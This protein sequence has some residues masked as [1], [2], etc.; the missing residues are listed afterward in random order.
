MC[1][2]TRIWQQ[3]PNKYRKLKN[4]PTITLFTVRAGK[5]SD[6]NRKLLAESKEGPRRQKMKRVRIVRQIQLI[7]HF[8]NRNKTVSKL[9]KISRNEFDASICS[10]QSK[11]IRLDQQSSAP[12]HLKTVLVQTVT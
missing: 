1:Y 11:Y 5:Q 4:L 8:L 6:E 10:M 2:V 9:I 3:H 7:E 12:F